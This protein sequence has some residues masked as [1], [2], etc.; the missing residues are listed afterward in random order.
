MSRSRIIPSLLAGL[1]L[2][3][4]LLAVPSAFADDGTQSETATIVENTTP[5]TAAK[6]QPEPYLIED[7]TT[8][9]EPA[10]S[11]AAPTQ[12]IQRTWFYKP[13][14]NN[15]TTPVRQYFQ[16]IILTRNDEK[17]RDAL[18]SQGVTGPFIQYVRLDAIM[19]PGSCTA[20]PWRNQVA[21]QIGD[22]CRI[23]AQHPDW[24]LRD[25]SGN[26]IVDVEGGIRFYLMD[27]GHRDWR[28]FV[29]NRVR[30]SQEQYGW[31]GVFLDNVEASLTK[32]RQRGA[33]PARYPDDATYQNAVAT[34]LRFL[35]SNYFAP[36]GRP[37]YGNI[38][39][40]K[41]P[42]VWFRYLAHLSGAMEEA[43]AVDWSNGYLSVSAWEEQL[44]RMEQT[45]A[46]GKRPI[47][48]SQ[49]AR[50]NTTRQQFAYASYLLIANGKAS[51]RYSNSSNYRD[52]WL[53]DNYNLNLGEPL[54]PRYKDGNTWRRDF[55]NATVRV[56]PVART[57]A[58]TPR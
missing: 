19:D 44:S 48:V 16:N 39:A 57:A 12:T 23:S 27:P 35:N 40:L 15:D 36:Q 4:S 37:L 43:F 47:L 8:L 25:T 58:I 6:V 32:R 1:V 55:T 49:G 14:V 22:F 9:V 24:F 3:N 45:Q 51:F 52:P 46:L 29:L 53:Y 7:E 38:I 33:L 11:A 34:F 50:D 2:L 17:F 20:Q 31:D 28:Y 10:Q 13:T 42:T 54:G 18:K 26:P 56:D 5:D 41:D 30:A 21:D